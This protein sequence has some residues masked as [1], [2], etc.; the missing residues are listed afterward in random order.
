MNAKIQE[1]NIDDNPTTEIETAIVL[2]VRKEDFFP[3]WKTLEIAGFILRNWEDREI[4]V[5]S[6]KTKKEI[7]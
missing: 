3:I 7:E 6:P 5:Y 2:E 1:V 4:I